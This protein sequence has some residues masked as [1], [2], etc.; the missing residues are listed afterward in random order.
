[1]LPPHL[2]STYKQYK[3]DTDRIAT[4]LAVTAKALGFDILQAT[5]GTQKPKPKPKTKSKRKTH[6][7]GPPEYTI[8]INDFTTLALHIVKHLKP[9]SKVSQA[10]LA[11]ITRAI[12]ARR[13]SNAWFQNNE[14]NAPPTEDGHAH[15]VGILQQVYAIPEP[16]SLQEANVDAQVDLNLSNMFAGLELQEESEEFEKVTAAQ[17]P[18]PSAEKKVLVKAQPMKDFMKLPFAAFTLYTDM[19]RIGTF[20][21]EL[22]TKHLAGQMDLISVSV[23][24]DCATDL[25]RRLEEDFFAEFP[26]ET[27]QT[28]LTMLYEIKCKLMDVAGVYQ[29]EGCRESWHPS[30]RQTV[31]WLFY[32]MREYLTEMAD[33]FPSQEKYIVPYNPFPKSLFS[34]V[35]MVL[36]DGVFLDRS[37][38][39]MADLINMFQECRLL[40]NYTERLPV[41]DEFLKSVRHITN[42]RKVPIW[43]TFVARMV[44]N[45]RHI[46]G[47][48][49]E[50]PFTQM[51]LV[52]HDARA[53]VQ[54]AIN[55]RKGCPNESWP[56][57][58]DFMVQKVLMHVI[59]QWI[60]T[61]GYNA[62]VKRHMSQ[63]NFPKED[64]RVLRQ[65]PILC[66]LMA[67]HVR[68]MMSNCGLSYM[69]SWG[70]GMFMAHLYNAVRQEKSCEV[71]WPD[72]ESFMDVHA[73]E[74]LFSNGRPQSPRDFYKRFELCM[75]APLDRYSKEKSRESQFKHFKRKKSG[76]RLL[77]EVGDLLLAL[78]PRYCDDGGFKMNMNAETRPVWDPD[79][80]EKMLNAKVKSA[81]D[82]ATV[83][84]LSPVELLTAMQESVSRELPVLTFDYFAFHC[85][86]WSILRTLEKLCRP[87]LLE[88]LNDDYRDHVD[89]SRLPWV[90]GYFLRIEAHVQS[91]VSVGHPEAR[92]VGLDTT[93]RIIL[94]LV[95]QFL[96]QILGG[97]HVALTQELDKVKNSKLM[98]DKTL[99]GKE[100]LPLPSTKIPKTGNGKPPRE[101]PTMHM[102]MDDRAFGYTEYQK[103]YFPRLAQQSMERLAGRPHSHLE[104]DGTRAAWFE[105]IDDHL[106]SDIMNKA[107]AP[108]LKEDRAFF[109]NSKYVQYFSDDM[110]KKALSGRF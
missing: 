91:D 45:V 10:V 93:S 19:N 51:Q 81:G 17:A 88:C 22:W 57:Q 82:E 33:Y 8:P 56:I 70:S 107:S 40:T 68:L 14:Q 27:P 97:P 20:V 9:P 30:M 6:S 63:A 41:E 24:A 38:D 108:Y 21:E 61:D 102:W 59:D 66:G 100:V 60:L 46:L 1:M 11:V 50:V 32:D 52:G 101:H 90:V 2:R 12:R 79:T 86:C 78:E 96:S 25:V 28:I 13:D 85:S 64:F 99:V 62:V 16:H 53:S 75:G 95:G 104:P 77:Q 87:K 67:F 55:N 72:M 7:T 92:L 15:F 26:N 106:R 42:T 34:N 110:K 76:A 18:T 39:E 37:E 54:A 74:C 98:F 44:L 23:T 29:E 5:S 31:R 103:Q 36:D 65:H 4:W 94:P 49:T 58:K 109:A 43:T 84:Q 48:S 73:V 80:V 105:E 83:R 35:F 47:N 89:E 69:N 71:E 3:E